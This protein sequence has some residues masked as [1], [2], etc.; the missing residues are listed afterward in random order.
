MSEEDIVESLMSELRAS[1]QRRMISDVPVGA[2]LSGGVDSSGILALMREQTAGE[3]KTYSIGFEGAPSYNE[4]DD[5]RKVARQFGANHIERIVG[6][7][8]IIELLPEIV[9]IYDEPL[10]DAPCTLR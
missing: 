2:F 5:A 1:V 7:E 10:A 4:T 6:P 9:D 8:D 3:I